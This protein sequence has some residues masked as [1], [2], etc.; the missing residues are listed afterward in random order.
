[1][2]IAVPL[3]LS[4]AAIVMPDRGTVV[5][6]LA[7]ETMGTGWRVLL[8]ARPDLDTAA[9]WRAIE[10]RL[11]IFVDELSHW[12]PASRLSRYNAAEAG[13]WHDLPPDFAA[14]MRAALDLAARTDGAFDPAIGELVELWGFGPRH[15]PIPPDRALLRAAL[16]R[17]GWE[18]LTLADDRLRQPGGAA[19]DLSGIAKG[20]A[21]DRIAGL[22]AE[23]GHANALVEIGGEYAG[24]GI[25]PDADPWWVELENPPGA[26]FPPLR[27]A[28]HQ[29]GVATSGDYVRGAHTLDPRSGRPITN[30]IVA[31]S[32]LHPHA[33]L[34]DGWA[35]ALAVL[36]PD[37]GAAMARREA[38][39]VRLLWRDEGGTWHE[40]LSP[41][42]KAML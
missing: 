19:L 11:A 2:R 21:V 8:A 23:A 40:H 34:A 3:H 24:R 35:S 30:G 4:P 17:A 32:V 42:L 14:I 28:L 33:M 39:A 31:V 36:G 7:G 13:S 37:A 1:M 26:P 22:L 6:E 20:R 25:R 18:R 27:I 10:D 9:L 12:L 41:M 15:L 5:H 16:S 29:M 38:L